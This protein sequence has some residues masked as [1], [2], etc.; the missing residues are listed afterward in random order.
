MKP[1]NYQA[2]L[3]NAKAMIN[4]L[5]YDCMR[6]AGKTKY[7]VSTLNELYVLVD[8][9]ENRLTPIKKS[10]SKTPKEEK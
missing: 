7:N 4:T 6:S 1:I 8:R 3:D 5:E 9:V 10:L 2:I